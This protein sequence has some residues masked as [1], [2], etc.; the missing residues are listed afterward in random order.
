M[1]SISPLTLALEPSGILSLWS[2]MYSHGLGDRSTLSVGGRYGDPFC[3]MATQD[4][5]SVCKFLIKLI[6]LQAGLVCLI[7]WSLS[8]FSVWGPLLHIQPSFETYLLIPLN[9]TSTVNNCSNRILIY[10][11]HSTPFQKDMK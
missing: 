10:S 3:P 6:N 7:L 1:L 11:L 9:F 8:S 5:V 4:C 2:R